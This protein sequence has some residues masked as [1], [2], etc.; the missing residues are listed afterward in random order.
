[1]IVAV[2]EEH[3]NIGG[4]CCKVLRSPIGSSAFHI[5][6]GGFS[7]FFHLHSPYFVFTLPSHS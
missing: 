2:V 7:H 5:G 6:L 1:M 4:F 3:R